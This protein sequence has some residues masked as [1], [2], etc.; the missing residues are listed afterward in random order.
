MQYLNE[1]V[2]QV[3]DETISR[4]LCGYLQV[5]ND[6]TLINTARRPRILCLPDRLPDYISLRT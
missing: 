2:T 4:V 6:P 3:S 1:L 5:S